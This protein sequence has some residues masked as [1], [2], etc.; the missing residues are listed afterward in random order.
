MAVV[1]LGAVLVLATAGIT[2]DF[3]NKP[4]NLIV[5]YAAGG[6]GDVVVRAMLDKS[7]EKLRPRHIF[8]PDETSRPRLVPRNGCSRVCQ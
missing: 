7:S 8:P 1:M 2:A 6:S 4:V 5:A 3:P